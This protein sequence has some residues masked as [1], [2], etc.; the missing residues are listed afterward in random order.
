MPRSGISGSYG[1]SI[2]SFLRNLCP[3]PQGGC[4][5]LYSHQ[6]CRGVPFSPKPLQALLSVDFW[7]MALLTCGLPRWLSGKEPACQCKRRK[8]RGFDPWVGRIS[9]RESM[10]PHSSILA[11]GIPW[12]GEPGGL[13]SR[14]WQRPPVRPDTTYKEGHRLYRNQT[15]T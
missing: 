15:D 5:N 13:Q 8:R 10:M 14:G 1:N 2:F 7:M 11:W 9:W 12:T 4:T 6:Q 3:I